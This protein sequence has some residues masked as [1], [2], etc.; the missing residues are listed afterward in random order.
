[1]RSIL[2]N[3]PLIKKS[4]KAADMVLISSTGLCGEDDFKFLPLKETRLQIAKARA[5]RSKRADM[6]WISDPRGIGPR[7]DLLDLNRLVTLMMTPIC[8]YGLAIAVVRPVATVLFNLP[9]PS[10]DIPHRP[11]PTLHDKCATIHMQRSVAK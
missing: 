6:P 5:T 4:A 8:R 3:P 9:V 11:P 1:M 2:P 7:V 10:L